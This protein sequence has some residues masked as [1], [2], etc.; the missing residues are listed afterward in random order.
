MSTVTLAIS[1]YIQ[2][3]I[4]SEQRTHGSKTRLTYRLEQTAFTSTEF[5][6][7]SN[8][9]IV[10]SKHEHNPMCYRQSEC[11]LLVIVYY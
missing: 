6:D 1:E 4:R 9:T 10:S 2:T 7:L 11:V 3:F 8:F 5:R